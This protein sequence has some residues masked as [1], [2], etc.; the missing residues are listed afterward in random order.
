LFELS[1][2]VEWLFAEAGDELGERIVAAA[3]AGLPA[4]E[5]WGW[6]GRD[7]AR[8]ACVLRETGVDLTACI[9]D[10]P[11]P[12]ADPQAHDQLMVAVAESA[13]AA[14]ALGCRN[15]IVVSGDR[16]ERVGDAAQRAAIVAALDRAAPIAAGRDVTL[17][18]EPLNS[19]VDHV[20][21]FLDSTGTGFEI[22]DEVGAP[23]VKLLLDL[24]HSAVMGEQLEAV[25]GTRVAEVGH[26][27]IADA[28]GRHEPGTGAI[29]W[30]HVFAWLDEQG[31]RG[32]IGLEYAPLASTGDT[33]AALRGVMDE[34]R[35]RRRRA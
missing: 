4:V 19:L 8:L 25:L 30:T 7:I 2:C 33:L 12:L 22:V 28:P 9:V 10:P 18:L 32:R 15:L 13:D 29:D 3:E 16:D 31:Y 20:G 34:G 27:H 5:F 26:I 21:T 24:Y 1:P 23:N 35:A 17:L 11:L 6:R 14:H